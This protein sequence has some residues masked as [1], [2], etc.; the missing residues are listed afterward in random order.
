MAWKTLPLTSGKTIK[1]Q[2]GESLPSP[3]LFSTL[4]SLPP[5][6]LFTPSLP[7]SLCLFPILSYLY[8]LSSH[9]PS[10]YMQ[11]GDLRQHCM[12]LCKLIVVH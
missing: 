2:V 4:P 5:L 12:L 9:T 1:Q 11:L 7:S 3:F 8:L 10:A 6:F